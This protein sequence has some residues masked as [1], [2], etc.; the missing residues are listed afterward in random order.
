MAFAAR[1]QRALPVLAVQAL[2][3]DKALTVTAAGSTQATATALSAAFNVVTTC[4]AGTDGVKIPVADSGDEIFVSNST[5]TATLYCYP[6]TG[7]AFNG[8]T[9]NVPIAIAPGRAARITYT[10]TLGG[11]AFF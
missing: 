10:N 9:A 4:V 1:L 3:Q 8:Q 7:G 11:A 5:T 2:L 6:A